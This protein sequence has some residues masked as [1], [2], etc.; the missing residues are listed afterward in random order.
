MLKPGQALDTLSAFSE[1]IRRLAELNITTVEEFVSLTNSEEARSRIAVFL[2]IDL[3][4]VERLRRVALESLP[5]DVR[6]EMS[7][8]VDTTMFGLGAVD[9]NKENP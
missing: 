2:S 4:S 7:S 1:S 9:P 8:P 3:N 6:R 5:D